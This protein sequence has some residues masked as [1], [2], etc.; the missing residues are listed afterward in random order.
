[1]YS[2]WISIFFFSEPFIESIIQVYILLALLF[3][4][5]KLITGENQTI[6]A[7]TF[8][9][10]ILSASLGIS[11][12]LLF[13]PCRISSGGY[14]QI[15]F[16]LIYGNVLF[17]LLAKGFLLTSSF[18]QSKIGVKFNASC[19]GDD[20]L[21]GGKINFILFWNCFVLLPQLIFVSIFLDF[22]KL[23]C[24]RIL[25]QP[26]ISSQNY[27][28]AESTLFRNQRFMLDEMT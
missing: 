25:K 15:R 23:F 4:K 20:G 27:F 14:A 2:K 9:S 18:C 7:I 24:F 3:Y 16:F 10:S 1:M 8:S 6:F 22:W 12:F 19:G 28:S 11:K 26:T 17:T 21:G 13:G 5:P